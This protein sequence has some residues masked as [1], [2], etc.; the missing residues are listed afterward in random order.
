VRIA[1]ML[2]LRVYQAPVDL[3]PI[4]LAVV[5]HRRNDR[6]PGY[7]WFR[8]QIMSAARSLD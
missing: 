6:D 5:W 4:S 8:Q 1:P 2:G 3:A 7:N